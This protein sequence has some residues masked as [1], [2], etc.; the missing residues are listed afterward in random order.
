MVFVAKTVLILKPNNIEIEVF[1]I[2]DVNS[3]SV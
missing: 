1:N 2:F 3:E